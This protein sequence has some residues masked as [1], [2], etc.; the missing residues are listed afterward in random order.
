MSGANSALFANGCDFCRGDVQ[1]FEK[2]LVLRRG[3]PFEFNVPTIHLLT[4]ES[5]LT[6]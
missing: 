1:E 3:G 2:F 4:R 6:S 5:T